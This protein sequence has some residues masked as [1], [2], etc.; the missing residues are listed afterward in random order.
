MGM[1]A[2]HIAG[3][4]LSDLGLEYLDLLLDGRR[5]DAMQ[6]VTCR[7]EDGLPVETVYV[8]VLQPVMYEVGRLWQADEIDI[9][10]EHY[11]T[12]A[13]QLL[14]ARLFPKALPNRRIA[15]SLVG[16]CLGSELHEMGMRMVCD[17]FEFTGWD[18]YF[19]GAVTPGQSLLKTIQSRKPDL[20]CLSATMAFGLPRIRDLI[21]SLRDTAQDAPPRIMVGGLPFVINPG[22]CAAVGADATAPDARRALSVAASLFD[23]GGRN[24]AQI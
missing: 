15:R 23:E 2:D 12:A 1:A 4:D 3:S 16:A 10:T 7:V 24:A 17:L 13:T 21:R 18:T 9:A 22:L 19:L 14:M 6:A 20:V 11:V 5:F 8:E